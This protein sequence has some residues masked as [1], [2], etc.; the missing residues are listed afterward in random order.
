MSPVQKALWLVESHLR[1]PLTLEEIAGHVGVSTFYLTRAFAAVTGLPL[2]RYVRARRLSEGA[3]LLAAGAPDILS[4]ALDTGYGSHEAFTRAFHDYFGLTPEQFRARGGSTLAA[5]MEPI[6]MDMTPMT[7]LPAPRFE[8]MKALLLAGISGR[9]NVQAT[10]A[11]SAQWVRFVP[12]L[13]HIRGQTGP[14]TYGASYNFDNEGNFDYL[15]SV[16]V[17]DFSDLPEGFA[18]LRVPAHKYAVFH[19]RGHIST[20][21]GTCAAIWST[22]LPTSGYEA[23]D[24]PMLERYG[25]EFDGL[26]G[27]GGFEIWVPL[28]P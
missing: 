2:M 27:N 6:N 26:S 16:E 5:L 12:H 25:P 23:A 1:E 8:T 14:I 11:I 20:I 21:G 7:D 17:S 10:G 28:K 24:G 13:G 9:Y 15:S 18:T 19:Q 4:V 3:R 22:W